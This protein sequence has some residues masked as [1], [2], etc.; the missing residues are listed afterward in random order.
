MQWN[1]KQDYVS[2]HREL[3]IIYSEL[4]RGEEVGVEAGEVV[5]LAPDFS[6]NV[7]GQRVLY[8]DRAL[9]KRD[10]AALRKAGLK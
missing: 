3:A 5:K 10:R 8:K 1:I 9:A 7:H 2:T 4:N 6:L